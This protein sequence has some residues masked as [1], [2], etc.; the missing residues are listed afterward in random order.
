MVIIYGECKFTTDV[1]HSPT[2]VKG[3]CPISLLVRLV[4]TRL[5]R[6]P[7]L[8]VQTIQNIN[9]KEIKESV[10]LIYREE[11]AFLMRV[12]VLGFAKKK[13]MSSGFD[14]KENVVFI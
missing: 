6:D 10:V 11:G 8:S 9:S 3:N 2:L 5:Y 14:M 4:T 13:L 12:I 1:H 7:S